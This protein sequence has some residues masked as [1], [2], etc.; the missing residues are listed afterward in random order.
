MEIRVNGEIRAVDN[1]SSVS[2][3]LEALELRPGRVAVELNRDVL[4]RELWAK[5]TLNAGDTLE[6]VQFVGGG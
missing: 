4:D 3:L 6:I 2:E 1:G 5:T